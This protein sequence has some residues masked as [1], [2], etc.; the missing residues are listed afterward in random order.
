[1][2]RSHPGETRPRHVVVFPALVALLLSVAGAAGGREWTV[3]GPPGG[4]VTALVQGPQPAGAIF[5]AVEHAGVLRSLDDGRTWEPAREGLP[6]GES[7]IDLWADRG[8]SATG[9]T[10]LAAT[11]HGLYRTDDGGGTWSPAGAGL[12]RDPSTGDPRRVERLAGDPGGSGRVYAL[13]GNTLWASLDGGLTWTEAGGSP[14]THL[15]SLAVDP[16]APESLLAGTGRGLYRSTNGGRT[17]RTLTPA[18]P[19][20]HPLDRPVGDVTFDASGAA[21][22][23][24]EGPWPYLL[25]SPDGGETWES[26]SPE[27]PR[28]S[29]RGRRV[30]SD[31]ESPAVLYLV[32]ETRIHRSEDGGRHWSEVRRVE[33]P[34]GTAGSG[35]PRAALVSRSGAVLVGVGDDGV[36]RSPDGL[37]DWRH[38]D[39]GMLAGEVSEV[40]AEPRGGVLYALRSDGRIERWDGPARGWTEAGPG[41]GSEPVR[42]ARIALDPARPGTLLAT[43]RAIDHGLLRSTDGGRTW[44]AAPSCYPAVDG[45]IAILPAASPGE[46]STVLLVEHG[47]RRSLSRDGGAS[48]GESA[49]F[50]GLG[51]GRFTSLTIDVSPPDTLYVAGAFGDPFAEGPVP[52]FHQTRLFSSTDRGATWSSSVIVP[53]EAWGPSWVGPLRVDPS[54]PERLWFLSME[55]SSREPTVPLLRSDDRGVSWTTVADVPIERSSAE[56]ADLALDPGRPDQLYASESD[57]RVLQSTDGGRTWSA[58]APELPPVAD[59]ELLRLEGSATLYAATAA[60]V[61]TLPLEDGAGPSDPGTDDPPEPPGAPPFADPALPGFRFW[62]RITAS[63]DSPPARL[64]DACIPETVCVSGAVPGRAELFMRI[65]GPKPNGRL[66]PTLVKLTTS[67]VEVWIEQLGSGARRYYRLRGASP[68]ADVLPGLFDRDGFVP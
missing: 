38:R 7:I 64:E 29:E 57:E 58:L 49:R 48:C 12:P 47:G 10:V 63:G 24:Q 56:V 30:A 37:G 32:Q 36:L 13:V 19:P 6:G 25:R 68:G 61:W 59:L 5:A 11:L 16:T 15:S 65:V 52:P 18:A 55:L 35:P 31:S 17:W 67:E 21:Y 14:A 34:P 26:L 8:P 3:L 20:G 50:P 9:G 40:V 54:D 60:G 27:L 1:M 44:R 28:L 45:R 23:A 39:G 42:A 62:V 2:Q 22:V 43:P 51:D 53:E 66:W 33:A 46:P 41:P 4:T